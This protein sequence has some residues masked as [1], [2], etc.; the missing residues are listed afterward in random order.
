MTGAP[1]FLFLDT[2]MQ[3]NLK[4]R[5]CM[6]WTREEVELPGHIS[7]ERRGEIIDEFA[8]MNPSGAVVICG[9]ESLM[10]PERYWPITQKCR[11][12]GLKC[13]SVMNGTM[14]TDA[15]MA[16]RLVLEGP[17]EITISLNSHI[18]DVHDET[19]GV[20]G[21]WELA[22]N[23]LR[24]L[25]EARDRLDPSI[26]IYAMAIVC[27]RNYRDLIDFYDF[28]L[29]DIKADKLKLNFLQPMFGPLRDEDNV[30]RDDKFYARNVIR[31]HDGLFEILRRCNELYDLNLDPEWMKT[32][33][34]YHR[35]VHRNDD[36]IKGWHGKGTEEL[37]CNSF[38]RNIM[39]DMFGVARLCFSHTFPGAQLRKDGD[40]R[41]FWTSNDALR[42]RM[43]QCRQYC[44]ISHSVRRV[45][46]TLRPQAGDAPVLLQAAEIETRNG[47][48]RKLGELARRL[49]GA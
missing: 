16:E 35:S 32:A 39:V 31:D 5:T 21:S 10:N 24:L 42:A 38:E 14:V 48:L 20:K 11:A 7:I 41:N 43:A 23:A 29:N 12:L 37:I 15:A 44:G 4:C 17:S 22:V 8:A 26:R 49:V 2:N 9:G 13:L 45:S 25:L 34:M 1:K 30:D 33:R 40:L 36:A 46:A 28:V 27:E 3:C 47:P 6:Y 18:S 19:R